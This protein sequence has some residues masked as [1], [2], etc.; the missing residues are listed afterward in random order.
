MRRGWLFQALTADRGAL[1]LVV[2][3]VLAGL[4]LAL[5]GNAIT[6][7]M[8]ADTNQAPVYVGVDA[9]VSVDGSAT[10]TLSMLFNDPEGQ[11]LS[12]VATSADGVDTAIT[13]DALTL[14]RLPGAIGTRTLTIIA[15]DGTTAT[16]HEITLNLGNEAVV[17]AP[18]GTRP[19][20]SQPETPSTIEQPIAPEEPAQAPVVLEPSVIM[21]VQERPLPTELSTPETGQLSP[22]GNFGIQDVLGAYGVTSGGIIYHCTTS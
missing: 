22:P 6:G 8:T 20:V 19:G 21:P 2:L 5:F 9:P 17:A 16:S 14:T 4:G 3:A 7:F 1:L 15:S 12:Y 13:G 11:T 18:T 10:I